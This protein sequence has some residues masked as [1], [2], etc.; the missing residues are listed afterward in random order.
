M[1]CN[2]NKVMNQSSFV[3]GNL[4]ITVQYLLVAMYKLEQV[5]IVIILDV[6]F[7]YNLP[8][9]II[10]KH[11]SAKIKIPSPNIIFIKI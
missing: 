3:Y 9:N 2:V 4:H 11:T 10:R 1:Q 6:F 5:I 8:M 7:Y